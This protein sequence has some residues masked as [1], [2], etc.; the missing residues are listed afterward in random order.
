MDFLFN[1]FNFLVSFPGF[2]PFLET[3]IFCWSPEGL[4]ARMTEWSYLE[5][6]LSLSIDFWASRGGGGRTEQG[7]RLAKAGGIGMVG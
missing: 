4:E 6:I 2:F 5:P 1:F 7:S 3:Q